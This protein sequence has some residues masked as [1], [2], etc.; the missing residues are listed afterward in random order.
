M[1]CSYFLGFFFL[2]LNV[3]IHLPSLKA[4]LFC[5]QLDPVSQRSLSTEFL[6]FY[7]LNFLFAKFQ[8]G[9]FSISILLLNSFFMS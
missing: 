9:I 7:L 8:F 3:L 6:K 2:F 1:F 5:L 4:L